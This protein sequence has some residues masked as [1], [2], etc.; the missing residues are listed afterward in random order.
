MPQSLVQIYVHIVFSTK[1]RA[2]FL[3][4][5][6]FRERLHAY[7]VGA[8]GGQG[9]PSLQVGGVEDHIHALVRL[10]KSIEVATLIREIKKESSKWVK[11]ESSLQDFHWQSGYG[12][13]S[14]SPSHVMSVV[15][16]IRDQEAHHEKESFQVEF[17]RICRKYDVAIDERYAWD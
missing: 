12:A 4:D 7:L 10:G 3:E 8:C 14:V 15:Q 16:Y 9:C 5:K 17:R 11:S 6:A 1:D 13:F 2:P